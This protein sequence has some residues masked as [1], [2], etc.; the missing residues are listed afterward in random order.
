MQL[1]GL[2]WL[3]FQTLGDEVLREGRPAAEEY[4]NHRDILDAVKARDANLAREHLAWHFNHLLR[5]RI[6][7]ASV[8]SDA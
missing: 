3:A 6:R 8:P 4:Q 7:R 5:E 2:F 1:Y